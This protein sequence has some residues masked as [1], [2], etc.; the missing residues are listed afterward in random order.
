MSGHKLA[1]KDG[2]FGTSDPFL[3][4]SRINEDGSWTPV[5]QSVKIDNSLNPLWAPARIPIRVL[6]NGDL[7]RP[8]KIEIF[9]WDKNG[10]HQTMGET[11]TS[12]N[13]MLANNGCA[14]NVVDPVKK[15]SSAGSLTAAHC[16]IEK[17]P[18]FSD[19]LFRLFFC[20]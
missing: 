13:S 11:K 14:M 9:D 15:G 12:V 17:Y 2:M 18:T 4:F 7:D 5:W 20:Q 8:L 19:V 6:C 10:K 16:I 3:V 1:N